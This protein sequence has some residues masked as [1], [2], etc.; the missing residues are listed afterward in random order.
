MTDGGFRWLLDTDLPPVRGGGV[1]AVHALDIARRPGR[2]G[3]REATALDRCLVTCDQE[4]RGVWLLT[5]EHK[6]IVIFEAQPLDHHEVERNLSMLEFRL[7]QY[8]D[9]SPAGNRYLLRTDRTVARIMDDGAEEE[10][11]PWKQV[12]TASAPGS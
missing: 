10:L 6:G 3:I 7:Q 5:G 8:G 12:K 2:T 11:A 9:T 4:F 1:D